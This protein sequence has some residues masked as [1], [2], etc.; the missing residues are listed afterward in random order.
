[1]RGAFFSALLELAEKDE[2]VNLVV[3]D[4]GFEVEESAAIPEI[5]GEWPSRI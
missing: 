4:L 3:G 5:S 2:R 1:M